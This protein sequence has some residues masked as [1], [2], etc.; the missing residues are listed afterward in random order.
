MFGMQ[1]AREANLDLPKECDYVV[2]K[3]MAGENTI[4]IMG[5]LMFLAY[6][7]WGAT[8]QKTAS[9]KPN[10]VLISAL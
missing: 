6:G 8:E 9:D 2:S 4:V 10:P 5:C 7:V 1:S 3:A